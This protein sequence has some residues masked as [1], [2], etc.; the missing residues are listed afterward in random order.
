MSFLTI[1]ASQSYKGHT[2]ERTETPVQIFFVVDGNLAAA[3][4]SVADA[5]R[6]INGQQ[7]VSLPVDIRR[8][9]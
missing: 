4:W 9:K 6:S 1:T 8:W 2:I 3:L 7:L 5:K